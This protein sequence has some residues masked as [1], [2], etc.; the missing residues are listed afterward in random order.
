DVQAVNLL[1]RAPIVDRGAA[2]RIDP[3][4][5][6]GLA[7]RV[8][9]YDMTQVPDVLDGEIP[10]MGGFRLKGGLVGDAP[11]ALAPT[12]EQFVG[13]AL[14]PA[15]HVGVGRAPV[16]RIVLETTVRRRVM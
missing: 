7:D 4:L 10:R 11:D 2:E 14:D 13:A 9:V 1:D 6:A 3:P 8:H 12:L 15:R 16:R 5:Q